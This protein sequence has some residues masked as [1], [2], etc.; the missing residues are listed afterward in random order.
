MG[1][2]AKIQE[3][4]TSINVWLHLAEVRAWGVRLVSVSEFQDAG[5]STCIILFFQEWWVEFPKWRHHIYTKK[6]FVAQPS[7]PRAGWSAWCAKSPLPARIQKQ[8]EEG[9]R[10]VPWDRYLSKSRILPYL[11]GNKLA[12]Y[13]FVS[14]G[15]RQESSEIETKDWWS[16]YSKQHEHCVG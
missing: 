9:H 16:W 6:A 4:K 12:C 15:R 7:S 1:Y 3:T 5:N 2:T 10:T 14:A 11:Q 8:T 13:Y